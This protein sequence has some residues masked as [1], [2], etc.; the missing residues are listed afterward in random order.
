MVYCC[1]DCCCGDF[2]FYGIVVCD[3]GVVVFGW[4]GGYFVYVGDWV[5]CGGVLGVFG[6]GIVL[7][8]VWFSVC[9]VGCCGCG[10]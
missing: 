8:C 9:G 1:C 10:L 4:F 5:W 6:V 2:D 7:E 3:S